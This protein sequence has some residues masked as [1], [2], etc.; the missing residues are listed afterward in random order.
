MGQSLYMRLLRQQSTPERSNLEN[1]LTEGLCDLLNRLTGQQQR[2]LLAAL[3]GANSLPP[4]GRDSAIRWKTQQ[5]VFIQDYNYKRPDLIGYLDGKPVYLVE[6]KVAAAFTHGR[7]QKTQETERKEPVDAH[8]LEMYGQWLA[9]TNTEAQ[10]VLLTWRSKAPDDFLGAESTQKYGV[11]ARH[12]ITW[13]NVHDKLAKRKDLPLAND[14]RTF[15]QEVAVATDAPNR[16]DFARLELFMDGAST[17]IRNFMMTIRTRLSTEFPAG[18]KWKA[19]ASYQSDGYVEEP[20]N[21]LIWAWGFLEGRTSD[22]ICWGM[23]FPTEEDIPWGWKAAFPDIPRRP[24]SF[25]SAAFKQPADANRLLAGIPTDP[26]WLRCFGGKVSSENEFP[27]LAVTPLED[28]LAQ[29]EP[30]EAVY[31]WIKSRFAEVLNAAS[32]LGKA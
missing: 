12:C 11:A 9:E 19:E 13:Q 8:Q 2:E 14:F 32:K 1:F 30:A 3:L 28:L 16:Q 22:Y 23:Y 7:T 31:E 21:R 17:R 29:A 26:H 5:T 20:E 10:L 24:V 6:V 27:C 15:L 18:M 4:Q 25:V